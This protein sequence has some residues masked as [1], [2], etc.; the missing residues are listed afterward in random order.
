MYNRF[1]FL[2]LLL[3]FLKATTFAAQPYFSIDHIQKGKDFNFPILNANRERRV[4]TKINQF[5]QLSEL[6][7]LVNRARTGVFD[8]A[9]IDDGSI[10]GSKVSLG[11][12]VNTNN[13]RVLS[14]S[15]DN[16]MDGAT[17]H[18]WTSYYNFNSQNGDCIALRDLFS[19]DGY[20]KFVDLV[21]RK[22]SAAYRSEV[23]RKVPLEDRTVFLGVLGS[24]EIDDLSDFAIGSHSITIDGQNL[25]G[26]SFCCES[27][28][29]EVRFEL[30]DFKRWLN[31]YGRL[32]FKLQKG[33]L[34]KFRSNQL[35]Q[36]FTGTVGGASPFV[37]ILRESGKGSVEGIYAYL[38]YR[39]A[40][41]LDGSIENGAV[42]LTEH[43]LVKTELRYETR[44]DHQYRDGGSISGRFDMFKLRGTWTD[45]HKQRSLEFIARRD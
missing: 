19:D 17:I 43:I 12:R 38:K 31:Q 40:I 22:R 7:G 23:V 13:P 41:Y 44:S 39:K 10:Y 9:T 30:R 4:E 33:N 20:V 42:R 27:L 34:A 26:K 21:K 24:I 35:P 18:W 11:Y 6:R 25:L 2:L 45:K 28:N 16:S 1:R 32:I 5:L 8:Q 37:A 3:I 36:L 15:F 29:M 14:I